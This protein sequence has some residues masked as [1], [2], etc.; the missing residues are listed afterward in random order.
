MILNV[1]AGDW[2]RNDKEN[3]DKKIPGF[4]DGI[5]AGGRDLR[6]SSKAAKFGGKKGTLWPIKETI[7]PSEIMKPGEQ[8]TNG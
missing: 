4:P 2:S 5:P 3:E 7:H 1:C 6:S 8:G